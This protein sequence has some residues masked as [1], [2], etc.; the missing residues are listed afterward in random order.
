[1]TN[2]IDINKGKPET[3]T[4]IEVDPDSEID[5]LEA[6][7]LIKLDIEAIGN[8]EGEM[9]Y[10]ATMTSTHDDDIIGKSACEAWNKIYSE[11][12]FFLIS[13]IAV[14]YMKIVLDAIEIIKENNE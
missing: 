11:N 5:I 4:V 10:I 9:Y 14:T 13:V 7:F 6:Y 1:M 12:G 8:V 2:V 3:I